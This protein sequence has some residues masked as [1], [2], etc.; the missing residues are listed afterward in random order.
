MVRLV[1]LSTAAAL[2]LALGACSGDDEVT[3][4]PSPSETV[5]TDPSAEPSAEESTSEPVPVSDNLDGISVS[6]ERLAMPNIEFTSP[7]A[8]D[9]TRSRVEIQ[10]DGTNKAT[11]DSTLLVMYIGVNGRSGETFDESYTDNMQ[12]PFDMTQVITGFQ[13][14]L[15]GKVAGDRVLIA[16]PSSDGYGDTGNSGAGIEA[17]DT[18]I[19]VVDIIQVAYSEPEGEAI[20]PESGLPTVEGE[21]DAPK[22]VIPSTEAPSEMKK[23]LLIEGTGATVKAEDT[24]MVNYAEYR[25]D[26]KSMVRQ[27]Y[28]YSPLTGALAQTIPGWQEALVDVPAGSRVLLVLPADK[29]YPDGNSNLDIPAGTAMVYVIDVLMTY[30]STSG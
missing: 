20:A 9:E 23:Q 10:G 27:T 26:T 21:T 11:A 13:K 6:G 15:E 22:V 3:P 4:S 5:M 25:W 2:L 24:I 8:I 1:A 19:F 17:G 7:F 18:L 28:G 30:Q 14:G 16:M 29:A 12:I